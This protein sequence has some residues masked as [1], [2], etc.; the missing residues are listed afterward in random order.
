MLRLAASNPI[1]HRFSEEQTVANHAR[2]GVDD[3]EDPED[4]KVSEDHPQEKRPHLAVE[5]DAAVV[6]DRPLDEP[7]QKGVESHPVKGRADG[8]ANRM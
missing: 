1:A 4:R 8:Q 5:M 3:P 7:G 6:Q 2:E